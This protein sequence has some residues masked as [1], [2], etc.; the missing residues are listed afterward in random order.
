M[1]LLNERKSFFKDKDIRLIIGFENGDIIRFNAT[2]NKRSHSFS[3]SFSFSLFVI[4]YRFT[5]IFLGEFN[6]Q[7]HGNCVEQL[8]WCQSLFYSNPYTEPLF[9]SK[10]ASGFVKVLIQ[11]F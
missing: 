4:E 2:T 11:Y 1:L 7:G 3:F 10:S 6:Y 8:Q 5:L 9:L